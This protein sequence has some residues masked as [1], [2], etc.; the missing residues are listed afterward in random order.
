MAGKKNMARVRLD[1]YFC[2]PKVAVSK[3]IEEDIEVPKCTPERGTQL[4]IKPLIISN[5]YE[6]D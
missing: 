6:I 2:V 1:Y 5:S 3:K 4:S